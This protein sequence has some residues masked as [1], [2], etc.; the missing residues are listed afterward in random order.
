M[1]ED[2]FNWL[3]MTDVDAIQSYLF[4]SIR[5]STIAGA[6]QIVV[7]ND[8]RIKEI[9]GNFGGI[10]LFSA[11]G[12]AVVLLR[13]ETSGT[14]QDFIEQA[15]KAFSQKSISG[16]LSTSDPID[17]HKYEHN[18][19]EAITAA[20]ESL[21]KNKRLGYLLGEAAIP[22]LARRCDTCGNEAAIAPHRF[23]EET[24]WLGPTCDAKR[25]ARERDW[26][27]LLKQHDEW[28][29]LRYKHLADDFSE[30]AGDDYL[31]VVVADVNGVGIRLREIQ[32]R[33][34]YVRFSKG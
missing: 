5:L 10:A 2:K 34:D 9:A 3:V 33:E 29:K 19:A 16:H 22:P 31:A 25:N 30:L 11:G 18:F 13:C 32:S 27:T 24:Y 15:K 8:K 28:S 23:G 6:S 21:E 26:L 14:A 4:S 17:L 1:S 20:A 12:A 7:D